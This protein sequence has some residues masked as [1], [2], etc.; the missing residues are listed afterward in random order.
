M[1]KCILIEDWLQTHNSYTQSGIAV[2]SFTIAVDRGFTNAS[3]EREADF[4]DMLHGGSR[5]RLVQTTSPKVA[6]LP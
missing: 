1:N 5:L 2:A 3:G 6:R 4:I